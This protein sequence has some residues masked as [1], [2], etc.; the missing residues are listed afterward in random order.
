MKQK[1]AWGS[2]L[3]IAILAGIALFTKVAVR[4]APSYPAELTAGVQ[5]GIASQAPCPSSYVGVPQAVENAASFIT[6]RSGATLSQAVK[7]RLTSLEQ[8]AMSGP[9]NP[10]GL[11][12]QQV[13]DV[14]TAN[15]MNTAT[16][17]TDAQIKNMAKTSLRVF[18]CL[19][20]SNRRDDVQLRGSKGNINS[21][22]FKQNAFLFRDGS[23]PEGLSLRAMAVTLIGGEID[24]RLDALAFA[25]P[26][27]WNVTYYSPYRV[28][29][30]AYALVS[31]DLLLKSQSEIASQMQSMET[32]LQNNRGIDCPSGGRCPYGE[33]GYIYSTPM[34]L[35]FSEGVQNDLLNRI[36][37]IV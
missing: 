7:Q 16:S 34:S 22:V 12:R 37:A 17:V 31:D 33:Q 6:Y 1:L 24:A 36:D 3:G 15:F 23:T 29:V 30:L 28:L 10:S 26:D 25:C 18:P 2:I 27:Q 9:P 20:D 35:F 5:S 19:A 13:K 11:T 21:G 4:S 8:S 14:I 32:W